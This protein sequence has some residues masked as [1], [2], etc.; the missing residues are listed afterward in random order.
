[1]I[2]RRC[3]LGRAGLAALLASVP[4]EVLGQ[5]EVPSRGAGFHAV[6]ARPGLAPL[7]GDDQTP[8]PVWGYDGVVPGPVLR[9]KRGE[10]LIV[11][12]INDLTEETTLHWHGVRLTN[13]MDGVPYLTQAP[14]APGES[15]EYHLTPPDAGTF[16]YHP[17]P[18]ASE[19][20]DRGLYGALI[21]DEAEPVLV[22][23][24]IV[25]VLK[26]W[27][28]DPTGS[29]DPAGGD[30]SNHFTVNAQSSLEVPVRA[31]E[32]L[33]L[34]L[35]NASRAR[36][37][38][39]VFDHHRVT[40]MAIDGQPAEPFAARDGHV[41]LGPGNRLDLFLDM[42]LAPGS[43]ARVFAA[44]RD[45]NV[46]LVR[47]TYDAGAAARAAPLAD[48]KPLP[49]NP[50]PARID[51]RNALRLDLPIDPARWTDGS[52]AASGRY[53]PPLFSARRGRPVVIAC[54]NRTADL[55]VLHLHGNHARILDNL[56]DGWK[57]F[58]VDTIMVA[59]QQT[60][61]IAFVADNPGKWLIHCRLLRRATAGLGVWFE[62]A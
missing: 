12:L 17:H 43:A 35:I 55:A 23:R 3:F 45:G 31:N 47:F 21:V 34:R 57:P 37:M 62:V 39:L 42:T 44:G 36:P 29:L 50:L 26:D 2:A 8:T 53:G 15:F 60:A 19:Q 7:R 46:P 61:R 41:A 9:V 49:A 20:L 56:D 25:L 32:R 5:G 14:I 40:V 48:P 16:W 6:R 30:T 10:A 58:W 27:R 24:D 13:A 54:T 22:D 4:S 28:L 38:S 51:L 52:V 1:M 18:F 33:R 59:A 11:R